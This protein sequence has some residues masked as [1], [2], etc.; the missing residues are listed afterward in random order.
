MLVTEGSSHAA[1]WRTFLDEK[2]AQQLELERQ[3]EELSNQI[4]FQLRLVNAMRAAHV[5]ACHPGAV[6]GCRHPFASS[7]SGQVE[8][9]PGTELRW[10]LSHFC[11]QIS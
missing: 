7:W 2:Q 9:C 8:N 1:V 10:E 11:K 4:E 5:H 3:V 6:A